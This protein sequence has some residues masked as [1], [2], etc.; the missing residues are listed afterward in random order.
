MLSL[1]TVKNKAAVKIVSFGSLDVTVGNVT[2]GRL[3]YRTFSETSKRKRR[4]TGICNM[5]DVCVVVFNHAGFTES[6]SVV[7]ESIAESCARQLR[8]GGRSVKRMTYDQLQTILLEERK[9]RI[10]IK[11]YQSE[12]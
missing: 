2:L 1:N 3:I 9:Q 12:V 11:H 4:I 5:S 10:S 8:S 6:V 7:D